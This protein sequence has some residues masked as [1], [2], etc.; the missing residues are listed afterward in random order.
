MSL[1]GSRAT[2]LLPSVQYTGRSAPM[3]YIPEYERDQQEPLHPQQT[4]LN[5]YSAESTYLEQREREQILAQ[6]RAREKEKQLERYE[7]IPPNY[8]NARPIPTTKI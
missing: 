2:S 1:T 8:L 3:T 4:H 7:Q 6:T 5:Q